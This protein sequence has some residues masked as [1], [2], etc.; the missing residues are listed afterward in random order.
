[1][2][3]RESPSPYYVG[4]GP[5]AKQVIFVAKNANFPAARRVSS[6]SVLLMEFHPVS[7]GSLAAEPR[8]KIVPTTIL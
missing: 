2:G 6:V 7:E 5:R 3:Q 4:N 1:M 8:R